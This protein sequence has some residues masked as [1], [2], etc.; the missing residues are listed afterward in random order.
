MSFLWSHSSGLQTKSKVNVINYSNKGV[1]KC[2]F[3][4]LFFLFFF[5]PQVS[6]WRNNN[7]KKGKSIYSAPLESKF[8]ALWSQ[9]ERISQK[10][11][12]NDDNCVSSIEER[13]MKYFVASGCTWKVGGLKV[14]LE[15]NFIFEQCVILSHVPALSP[16]VPTHPK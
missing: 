14:I 12:K 3:F 11:N 6:Y 13:K 9:K 7:K 16:E 1:K 5:S 8:S 15:R 4:C 10:N 2:V